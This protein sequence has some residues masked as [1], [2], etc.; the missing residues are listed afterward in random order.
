MNKSNL[1]YLRSA[2][3][4]SDAVDREAGM[5]ALQSV[6]AALMTNNPKAVAACADDLD[7]LT[8]QFDALQFW[9]AWAAKQAADARAV[10]RPIAGPSPSLALLLVLALSDLTV[11]ASAKVRAAQRIEAEGGCYGTHS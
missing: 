11:E 4:S 10:G 9:T 5:H 6:I 3:T 8:E 7:A 2:F 1:A